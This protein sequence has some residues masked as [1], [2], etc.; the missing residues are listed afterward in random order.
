MPPEGGIFFEAVEA[1]S[2]LV[3]PVAVNE[4][5]FAPGI[6]PFGFDWSFA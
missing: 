2:A 3:P 6:V 5:T 1:Y 4:G